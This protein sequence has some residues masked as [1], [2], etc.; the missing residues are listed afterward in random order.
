MSRLLC[1]PQ[2]L[3]YFFVF[4]VERLTYCIVMSVSDSLKLWNQLTDFNELVPLEVS[5]FLHKIFL[6]CSSLS[7]LNTVTDR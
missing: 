7:K 6:S 1:N 4:Y 5:I 2:V 3:A